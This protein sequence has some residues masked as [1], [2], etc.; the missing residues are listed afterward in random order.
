MTTLALAHVQS[1]THFNAAFY[2]TAATVIPVLFLAVAVQGS[3]YQDLLKAAGAMYKR[4]RRDQIIR[5]VAMTLPLIPALFILV[6]GV[7]GEIVAISSLDLQR[8]VG[9]GNPTVIAAIITLTAAAALT[10][11]VSYLKLTTSWMRTAR[12]AT[13]SQ[14]APVA[15][16][17]KEENTA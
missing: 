17:A 13:I 9:G 12:P 3:T 16:P 15:D 10:P 14:Q 2:S 4:T 1:T 11:V 6:Y 7:Q 5:K 8:Q